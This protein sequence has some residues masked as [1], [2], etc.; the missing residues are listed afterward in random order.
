[1]R[2]ST[3]SKLCKF[4]PLAIT[5]ADARNGCVG[6]VTESGQWVRPEPIYVEDLERPDTRYRYFHWTSA[7]LKPST[8]EQVRPEDRDI[9]PAEGKPQLLFALP[10]SERLAFLL[11]HA[12]ANVEAAL[13]G[14]RSLGLVE[15]SV[16]SFYIR[17]STGGRS[18]VRGQFSD[19]SGEGF[20][21]IVPEI[22]FGRVVWPH[23]V[24]GAFSRALDARLSETFARV[25]TF[26]TVGL[27]KPNFRFPGK[28]RNCH[29]L[30]VGIHSE[31]HYL[32]VLETMPRIERIG[33]EQS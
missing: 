27:T 22:E 25:R 26:F 28:F 12:D 6:A 21:W 16:K 10:E 13:A 4:L 31:P 1:M 8:A 33:C 23:V 32:R 2:E 14:Q 15:V 18:F 3:I 7:Y 17:Q 24:E 11:Q 19:A 20:D 5:R 29:P 30:I 9:S